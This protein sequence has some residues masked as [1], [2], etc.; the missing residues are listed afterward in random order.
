MPHGHL[1]QHVA[2]CC[3]HHCEACASCRRWCEL[4]EES[5]I[6]IGGNG[7]QKTRRPCVPIPAEDVECA[8]DEWIEVPQQQ[9]RRGLQ[10]GH[11]LFG[12]LRVWVL[13]KIPEGGI[14]RPNQRCENLLHPHPERLRFA[15]LSIAGNRRRMREPEMQFP[16]LRRHAFR[17]EDG[18][19][20]T[21]KAH[22]APPL[23]E[24]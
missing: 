19:Q 15:L 12:L 24:G 9:I 18:P 10:Y 20:V 5:I 14:E 2:T 21:C 6:V 13:G 11:H 3:I 1:R 23:R 7:P 4:E 16:L 22:G 8:A 17:I